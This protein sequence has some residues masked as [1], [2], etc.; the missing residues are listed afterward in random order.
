MCHRES[1]LLAELAQELA[2]EQRQ[3]VWVDGTLR[4]FEWRFKTASAFLS[5][6][7]LFSSTF[8]NWRAKRIENGPS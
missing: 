7:A 2:I 8:P 6:K 5:K 4:D 3:N 1:G